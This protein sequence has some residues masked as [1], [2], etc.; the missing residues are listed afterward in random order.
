MVDKVTSQD[1]ADG[2]NILIQNT[3]NTF[4]SAIVSRKNISKKITADRIIQLEEALKIAKELQI[5]ERSTKMSNQQSVILTENENLQSK[6]PIY[7]AGTKA[8][9]AEINALKNRTNSESF[10]TG[11]RQLQQ[12]VTSLDS[13]QVNAKDVRASQV[14]QKALPPEIRHSPKRKLIVL[15][16]LLFGLIIAFFYL[17]LS[18]IIRKE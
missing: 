10:I 3:K 5:I 14:D 16:G 1:Y 13:I 2:I 6:D 7:L 12:K 18:F 9:Q 17:I 4:K 11:L 8:I 15:L